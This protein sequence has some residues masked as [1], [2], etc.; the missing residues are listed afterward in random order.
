MHIRQQIREAFALQITGVTG[1]GVRVFQNRTDNLS[2]ADLP[3]LRI[4]IETEHIED[5]DV[6][7]APTLQ[8]RTI[9]LVCEAVAK[10][11]S[12]LDDALDSLCEQVELAIAANSRLGN[13]VKLHCKL[14]A[15]AIT[16]DG[17]MESPVGVAKMHWQLVA[18][19]MSDHP[20]IAL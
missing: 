11:T 13:L 15:T 1:A 4:F 7:D 14:M 6:L 12:N 9:N 8:H 16:L 5:D 20:D 19:T 3:A 2:D 10:V 18:L 17:G